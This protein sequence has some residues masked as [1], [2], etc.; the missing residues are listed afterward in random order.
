MYIY[1]GQAFL[2][3]I[4]KVG[5]KRIMQKLLFLHFDERI[6]CKIYQIFVSFY[7]A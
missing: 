1:C 2:Y 5:Q 7:M 6:Q 4:L 3:D